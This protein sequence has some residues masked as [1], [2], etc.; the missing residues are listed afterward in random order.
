[1]FQVGGRFEDGAVIYELK[2]PSPRA[3]NAHGIL[4]M[5]VSLVSHLVNKIYSVCR[6]LF[7]I[8]DA[9]IL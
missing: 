1:M 6:K 3:K 2:C 9:E 4:F 7:L 8:C 5:A